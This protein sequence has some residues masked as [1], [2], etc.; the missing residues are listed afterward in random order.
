MSSLQHG[1]DIQGASDMPGPLALDG[2][3]GGAQVQAVMVFTISGRE[4]GMKVVGNFLAFQDGQLF[5]CGCVQGANID[6]G[7]AGQ[8]GVEMGDL[9]QGMHPGIGTP[10]TYHQ[11]R[12][13]TQGYE[14]LFQNPLDG[15]LIGLPLPA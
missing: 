15:C 10:S 2:R 6:P 8:G 7:V 14:L 1:I 4:A 12:V 5:G 3:R 9:S 11:H 13:S